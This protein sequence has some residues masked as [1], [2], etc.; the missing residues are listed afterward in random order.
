MP[1]PSLRELT[2][3]DSELILILYFLSQPSSLWQWPVNTRYEV[4]GLLWL[5]SQLIQSSRKTWRI[6]SL[7]TRSLLIDILLWRICLPHLP[8]KL[9]S[10]PIGAWKEIRKLL[11]TDQ[12]TDLRTHTAHREVWK[13]LFYRAIGNSTV[14]SDIHVHTSF[15]YLKLV[16]EWVDVLLGLQFSLKLLLQS[17]QFLLTKF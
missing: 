6:I 17:L 8:V 9:T 14:F 4:L 5:W 7:I 13:L 16:D 10:A 3:T 12:Q 1:K 2:T 11:R 15:Y